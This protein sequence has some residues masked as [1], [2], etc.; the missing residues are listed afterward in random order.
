MIVKT[1]EDINQ[2][3]DARIEEG[4]TLEYKRQ[5][6]SNTDIAKDISAFANTDGGTIVYGVLDR[7]KIPTSIVWVTT[8]GVEEKIQNVV[9]TAIH[10]IVEDIKIL[11][12]PNPQNNSEAIYVIKVPKSLEAPHM[13]NNRY[14][15]RHGSISIA[16]DHEEVKTALLGKG[17]T[18]ALT[19]EISANLSLLDRT[20]ALI[21]RVYVISPQKR[22]RIA[23]VP[24]HTDA[25]NAIVATGLMFGFSEEITKLLVET[26]A[27]IHE[28]N[29]LTEWL[30]IEVEPIVHTPADE[31]SWK[32]AGTYV[33]AT[34]R[35][36]LTKLR[37]LLQ[38]AAA[39]LGS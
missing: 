14:Y 6:S 28:I 8:T 24:F 20:H 29:S 7:D 18:A 23:I 19:F 35:D 13:A 22:K 39:G 1:L 15:K 17:R 10:P 21:E 16:M 26:Y 38:Q 32:E 27:L 30:K 34:V 31:D 12:L 37:T 9:A 5:V 25:W 4:L 2:F 33:P 3:I 11:R 36:K